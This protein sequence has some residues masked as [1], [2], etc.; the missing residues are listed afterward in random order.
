MRI[1]DSKHPDW[2]EMIGRAPQLGEHLSDESATQFEQVQAGLRDLGVDFEIEPRLVRGFDY[3]TATVFEFQSPALSG[4]QNAIGGGGRYDRLSEEMGGPAAPAI[5]FGTGIERILLARA[6]GRDGAAA[7]VPR[8]DVFVID[9]VDT[10]DATTLLHEVRELGLRADRAYGSLGGAARSMKKQ[11]S[12]ADRSGA[13]YA[14]MVAPREFA[15]GHVVVKDLTSG[16]QIEVR[17][18]EAPAWLRV[19]TEVGVLP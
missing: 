18:E 5:G 14:V 9:A 1:L 17:R 2:Q 16:E 7:A 15:T 3:Y 19:H 10:G 8:L 6:A 13:R 4:A 12:A 11:W